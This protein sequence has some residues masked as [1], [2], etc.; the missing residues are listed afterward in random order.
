MRVMFVAH[1]L[2]V[3]VGEPIDLLD[4]WIQFEG[5]EWQGR[6]SDLEAGLVEV[7]VVEVGITQRVNE[8]SRLQAAYLGH[9]LRQQRVGCDVERDAEKDVGA[10]LVELTVQTTIG[11][12]KLEKGMTWH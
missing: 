6:S 5:G 2:N 9:H 10:S 8:Y 3:V 11:D 4:V 7:V 12:V 1:H